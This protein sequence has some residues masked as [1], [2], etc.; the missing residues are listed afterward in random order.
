MS[1]SEYGSA[2][3][4]RAT[5]LTG[6]GLV[7]AKRARFRK[8]LVQH[9]GGG[10]EEI[11]FYDLDTAPVGGEPY[12]TFWA[13]GKG[14]YEVNMPDEGVIFQN[15]IYISDDGASAALITVFFEEF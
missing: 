5:Q 2:R 11:K 15:G 1:F 12:Y 7:T 10:D 6:S 14:T 4:I 3:G 9:L 13:F 8:L